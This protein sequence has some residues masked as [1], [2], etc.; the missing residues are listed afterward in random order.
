MQLFIVLHV[1]CRYLMMPS[2]KEA[3]VIA[4]TDAPLPSSGAARDCT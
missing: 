3:S 4:V 2:E 1:L